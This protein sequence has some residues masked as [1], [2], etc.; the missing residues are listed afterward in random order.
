MFKDYRI[1]DVVTIKKDL[2]AGRKYDNGVQFNHDM[3]EYRGKNAIVI[4]INDYG[5]RLAI[6]KG[7]STW[8]WSMIEPFF[9]EDRRE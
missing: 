5:C 7:S 3:L 1:G 9:V 6:D 8:S 4:N 2:K